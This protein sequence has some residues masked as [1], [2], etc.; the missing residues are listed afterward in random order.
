[1]CTR[2]K[3]AR[4][5]NGQ[6]TVHFLALAAETLITFF[7]RCI[8]R[9]INYFT[10]H[11]CRS[12][13]RTRRLLKIDRHSNGDDREDCPYTSA[14]AQSRTRVRDRLQNTSGSAI[15]L[16]VNIIHFLFYVS[17]L[18]MW[19]APKVAH[20]FTILTLRVA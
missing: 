4:K 10:T 16:A 15:P 19:S 3:S 9:H 14:C 12:C 1:M 13:K 2:Q 17:N 5:T 8:S 6:S 18:T 7:T 11:R 20:F